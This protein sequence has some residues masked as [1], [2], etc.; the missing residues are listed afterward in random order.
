[1]S[2]STSAIKMY[3]I[4]GVTG[5][6]GKAHLTRGK[7][8]KTRLFLVSYVFPSVQNHLPCENIIENSI[9]REFSFSIGIVVYFQFSCFT[10]Y[11]FFP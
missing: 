8:N 11:S 9:K 2:M 10:K 6:G 4:V 7:V 3:T 1:M 5:A